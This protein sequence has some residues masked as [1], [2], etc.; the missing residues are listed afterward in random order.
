MYILNFF[1]TIKAEDTEALGRQ[2]ARSKP[3]TVDFRMVLT[4]RLSGVVNRE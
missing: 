4:V 1:S 2:R 3:D